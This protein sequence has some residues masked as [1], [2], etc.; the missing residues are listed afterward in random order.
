M[1]FAVPVLALFLLQTA[2]PATLSLAQ[3]P[4]VKSE[5]EVK[6]QI[7]LNLPL[8]AGWPEGAAPPDGRIGLCTLSE[9]KVAA[10]LQTMASLPS[11]ANQIRYLPQVTM[12]QLG[13]CQVIFVDEQDAPRMDAVLAAVAGKP[14]LTVGAPRGFASGKGMI[15][16][17]NTQKNIG[18]FSEK[19]VKF[20]INLRNTA[21]VG[22]TLDPL[23]LELAETIIGGE[24]AR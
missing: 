7:I 23:L 19:N 11:Y 13:E 18:L 1:K 22:I 16:F 12:T 9:G 6:A 5:A 21:A 10:Y 20:S 15:G 8:V 3:S 4:A 14:V 17:L 2:A 24:E